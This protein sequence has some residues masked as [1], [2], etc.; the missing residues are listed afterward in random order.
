MHKRDTTVIELLDIVS[1]IT[2]AM[3]HGVKNIIDLGGKLRE[4]TELAQK[5]LKE[6]WQRVKGGDI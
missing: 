3:Y 4:A 5:I 6:E 2:D 1:G